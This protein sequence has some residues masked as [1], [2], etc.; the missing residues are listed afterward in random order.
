MWWF[1]TVCTLF[2]AYGVRTVTY[3][4]LLAMLCQGGR[5]DEYQLVTYIAGIKH[6]QYLVGGMFSMVV[7]AVRSFYCISAEKDDIQA[8]VHRDGYVA[9]SLETQVIDYLGGFVLAWFAFC[10]IRFSTKKAY[11]YVVEEDMTSG[12]MSESPSGTDREGKG[13]VADPRLKGIMCYDLVVFLFSLVLLAAVTVLTCGFDFCEDNHMQFRMNI[14]W[15]RTLYG[16]MTFPFLL[17]AAP[18]AGINVTLLTRAQ[19][20][21]YNAQGSC[22]PWSLPVR[23]AEQP[24]EMADD[25][26]SRA[27]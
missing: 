19:P 21:G 22:V 23:A 24:E 6:T 3:A 4:L 9:L 15:C 10:G 7:G 14:F 11:R 12:S 26:H 25:S 16:L 27:V 17:T 5:P 2:P 20:T 1:V 18:L 8:C 13:G